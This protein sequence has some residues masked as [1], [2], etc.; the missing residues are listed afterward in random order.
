MKD[1]PPERFYLSA[2][3]RRPPLPPRGLETPQGRKA[4]PALHAVSGPAA[5]HEVSAVDGRRHTGKT[6]PRPT[7]VASVGFVLRHSYFVLRLCPLSFVLHPRSEDE[8][9]GRTV[10]SRRDL[11]ETGR[12][13]RAYRCALCVS[14]VGFL[15]TCATTKSAKARMKVGES[16]RAGMSSNCSMSSF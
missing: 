11:G 3:S 8:F 12:C 15:S 9:P 5:A 1:V 6:T 14:A 10:A 16:F 2:G 4:G 7:R 13:L